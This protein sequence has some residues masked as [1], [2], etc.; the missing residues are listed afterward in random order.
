MKKRIFSLK[1]LALITGVSLAFLVGQVTWW[2]VLFICLIYDCFN[3]FVDN[4]A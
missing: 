1:I 3:F 4:N 2:Q